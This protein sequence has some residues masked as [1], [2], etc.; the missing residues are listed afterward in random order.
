MLL[1]KENCLSRLLYAIVMLVR[2]SCTDARSQVVK[3]ASQSGGWASASV[4]KKYPPGPGSEL[5]SATVTTDQ[6]S[7]FYPGNIAHSETSR[8]GTKAGQYP[9]PVSAIIFAPCVEISNSPFGGL[10]FAIWT[11][12]KMR[13]GWGDM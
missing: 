9:T 2:E 5:R 11:Q 7:S 8:A 12:A 4:S 3:I 10:L 6:V 13:C 1:A